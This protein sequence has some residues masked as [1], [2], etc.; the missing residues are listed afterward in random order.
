MLKTLMGSP[1][2]WIILAVCTVFS[3]F[4]AIYTK[5]SGKKRKQFSYYIKTNELVLKGS[6]QIKNLT[7][8]YAGKEIPDLSISHFYIWNSGNLVV[9]N[10]DIVSAKP[11]CIKNTAES[12]IL[13]AVIIRENEETNAFSISSHEE[14]AIID[15]DYVEPG[16]GILVQV[17]HTGP[18][19]DIE[20]DCKIKGGEQLRDASFSEN[21]AKVSNT[22]RIINAVSGWLPMIMLILVVF[23]S[24]LL[25]SLMQKEGLLPQKLPT[26][27]FGDS[28]AC[29]NW[30]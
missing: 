25:I 14:K 24:V 20:I 22:D 7:V 27:V 18:I 26:L 13:E 21:K 8:S 9:N 6:S 11:L 17:L 1:V 23:G 15:F 3:T 4:Y 2:A 16:Q 5:M 12:T 10:D 30:L 28:R 29:S 19:K